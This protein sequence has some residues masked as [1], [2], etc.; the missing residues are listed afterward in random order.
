VS[1]RKGA[2]H[3]SDRGSTEDEI[4][5]IRELCKKREKAFSQVAKQ[6]GIT[7]EH[8]KKIEACEK[9]TRMHRKASQQP[10]QTTAAD[11]INKKTK[12]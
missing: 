10:P 8:I 3:M 7:P 6:S 2:K 5:K 11:Q 4:N 12:T 9:T 1:L